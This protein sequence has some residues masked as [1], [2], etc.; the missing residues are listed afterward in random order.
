MRLFCSL[1][2]S[3]VASE[4]WFVHA[5]F[6]GGSASDFMHTAVHSVL[7]TD[8]HWLKFCEFLHLRFGTKDP[9]A[10]FWDHLHSCLEIA[11]AVVLCLF[12]LMMRPWVKVYYDPP[13][14]SDKVCVVIGSLGLTM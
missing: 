14:V 6:V 12:L 7:E 3:E 5:M 4:K 1:K 13:V 8:H 10:G 11:L 2:L 9:A